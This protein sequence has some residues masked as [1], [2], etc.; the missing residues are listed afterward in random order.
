MLLLT[1]VT[2]VMLGA[3]GCT[4]PTPA[5]TPPSVSWSPGPPS[6]EHEDS[7]WVKA[8][9]ASDTAL[10]IA[11]VTRDYTAAELGRTTTVPAMRRAAEAQRRAAKEDDFYAYPGPTPMTVLSVEETDHNHA[12]VLVC[13]AGDWYLESGKQTTAPTTL[14]GRTVEYRLV[15]TI[16]DR[17]RL[18]MSIP[19]TDSACD[20]GDVAVGRFDPQP[21]VSKGY[22][23]SDVKGP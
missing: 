18:D 6:G 13:E 16:N 19:H 1:A 8:L 5:P 9:R 2:A 10:A 22:S 15:G 17:I 12:T 20:L 14:E 3:T 21:D 4:P 7:P 11:S 23:P